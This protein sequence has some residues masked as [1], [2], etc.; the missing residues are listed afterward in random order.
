MKLS[1]Q[2]PRSS[3]SIDMERSSLLDFKITTLRADNGEK[4]TNLLSYRNAHDFD[5]HLRFQE[6]GH[7]YWIKGVDRDVISGTT[8]IHKYF[9]HFDAEKIIRRIVNSNKWATDPTY[10]YY[11]QTSEDIAAGWAKNGAEASE[12]GTILHA[13]ISTPSRALTSRTT[14]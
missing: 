3:K 12:L 11:Q 2:I 1:T 10:R 4:N 13:M 8:V 14:A 7:I 9:P 6:E 5:Q